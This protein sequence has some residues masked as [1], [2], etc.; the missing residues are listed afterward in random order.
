MYNVRLVLR[1]GGLTAPP[2]RRLDVTPL[3]PSCTMVCTMICWIPKLNY[4]RCRSRMVLRPMPRQ[5]P[6]SK[7]QKNDSAHGDRTSE[8][9]HGTSNINYGTSNI[10]N[11]KSNASIHACK[12]TCMYVIIHVYV[13][14]HAHPV[15]L[16]SRPS[17]DSVRRSIS[18][19]RC[20]VF[21]V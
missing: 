18:D 5:C 4:I 3:S 11:R 21:D 8:I 9:D 10:E 12:H 14:V 2:G 6:P 17:I 7:E 20:S 1:L 13:N 19:V 16:E 15:G